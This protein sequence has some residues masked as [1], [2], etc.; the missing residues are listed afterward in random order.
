MIPQ[1]TKCKF[2]RF[3]DKILSNISQKSVTD[4]KSEKKQ[5]TKKVLKK[6]IVKYKETSVPKETKLSKPKY[7]RI[8]WS[9][10]E[11]KITT[12]YFKKHILL[13]RAP[14]KK[15]CED[16]KKK[17]QLLKDKPWRKIK[18]FIHNI[19]MNNK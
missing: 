3:Q 11:R 12:D 2:Q 5:G 6:R 17:F 7:I 14:Q 16:F 1:K 4:Q 13:N 8:P 9:D 18:T 10:E 15:E 19:C